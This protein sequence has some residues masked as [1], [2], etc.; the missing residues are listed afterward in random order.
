MI[1]EQDAVRRLVLLCPAF[2]DSLVS[3]RD[4]G[5]TEEESF[6]FIAEFA[7]W[8]VRQVK[9]GDL[10]CLAELFSEYETILSDASPDAWQVLVAGFMEDLHDFT[11]RMHK[12]IDQIDPDVFLPFLGTK[13]RD[14]WFRLVRRYIENGETWPGRTA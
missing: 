14:A 12:P 13:S 1:S 11:V 8:V 10:T 5:G 2:H 4:S 9:A 6:N 7:D 3:Y